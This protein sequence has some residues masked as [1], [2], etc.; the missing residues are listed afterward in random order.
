MKQQSSSP[1]PVPRCITGE[2]VC[3][4]AYVKEKREVEEGVSEMDGGRSTR[5][6]MHA[7][8]M[9]AYIFAIEGC[10]TQLKPH[11]HLKLLALQESAAV[12]VNLCV[13]AG[14]EPEGEGEGVSP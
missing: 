1:P 3:V 12:R 5:V 13:C 7:C 9:H 6:S 4:L 14:R 2:Y 10:H 8:S 11:C